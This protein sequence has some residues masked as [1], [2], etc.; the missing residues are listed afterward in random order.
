MARLLQA[1][2]AAEATEL[3]DQALLESGDDPVL[4]V[5]WLLDQYPLESAMISTITHRLTVLLALRVLLAFAP[6]TEDL[7]RDAESQCMDG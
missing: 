1:D 5:K 7:L 3:V 2:A 4:A 6:K